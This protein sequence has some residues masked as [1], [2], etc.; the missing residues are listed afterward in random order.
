M[1]NLHTTRGLGTGNIPLNLAEII[2][3]KANKEFK[4]GT[5]L[6]KVSL[7]TQ[8][9]L[10]FWDPNGS[11]ADVRKFNFHEG[12]WQAI[13][14]TIYVHDILKIKDVHDMYMSV[15]SDLLQEMNLVDLKKDKYS[16]PKYCIK[17]GNWYW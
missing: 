12:Q 7:M 2:S 8:D 6:D 5:F 10:K 15:H 1:A 3:K 4:D 9:L 14:N 13:I 11:F 17:N 16:N